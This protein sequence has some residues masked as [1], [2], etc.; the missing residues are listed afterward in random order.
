MQIWL[1]HTRG[2]FFFCRFACHYFVHSSF[3]SLP[4]FALHPG[5]LHSAPISPVR[6][7]NCAVTHTAYPSSSGAIHEAKGFAMLPMPPNQSVSQDAADA[8]A[9][10][11]VVV[12]R[13]VEMNRSVC[14]MLLTLGNL[15]LD[16]CT[17]GF[18]KPQV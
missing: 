18:C 5:L 11:Q 4:L 2:T 12:S 3:L 13:L 9:A 10:A 6:Y 1:T 8:A 16:L 7:L 15:G 17:N 14:K